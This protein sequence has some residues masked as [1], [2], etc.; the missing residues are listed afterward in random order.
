MVAPNKVVRAAIFDLDNCLS[1][2]DEPGKELLEPVFVAIR[3][4]NH[5]HLSEEVL[6]QKHHFPPEMLAAAW[7][8]YATLEVRV[9]MRGY[10]DLGTLTELPVMRFLVTS[11][12]RRMQESKIRALGF[13]SWFTGIHIDAIDDPNR[14]GKE[15]AFRNILAQHCLK[16]E[17][18]DNPDSEIEAGNRIGVT[19][20]QILRPSVRPGNN[21]THTIK[22][23]AELKPLINAVR[24]V[25]G[26]HC[27]PPALPES[28]VVRQV[29]ASPIRL[30]SAVAAKAKP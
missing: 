15:A 24:E 21:A 3:R 10:P 18:G 1:A 11:G 12:F 8:A 19:T 13:A 4:N 22:R 20:V 16:P 26:G 23:L 28:P 25:A 6:A 2:A 29:T 5:G 14:V 9:P 17:V 7:A 27:S 30:G